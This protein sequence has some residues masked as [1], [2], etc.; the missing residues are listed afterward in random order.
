MRT[1]H[2]EMRISKFLLFSM[3]IC[4]FLPPSSPDPNDESCLTH[5]FQSFVDPNKN[6]RNWTIPNFSNPCSDFNSMLVGAT[7]N[8]G[9]VYKLSLQNLGLRGPISPFISNCTNLQSLDLSNNSLAGP[10]P[11]ELQYL[12]NLAVLNLSS[13]HLSAAIPPSLAMCNYLNVIDLHDNDLTGTI[14]PQLGSLVRLSVFDVS[15]NKLSGPI[16]A[17]LGNRMGNLPRLNAS[18]FSGN[19]DLYGYPLGP[20]NSKGLSVVAIVGIGLGSGLLSLVLSFT[21]VCI[22][23]RS[24]E[25]KR[26]DEHEGKIPHSMPDY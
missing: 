17:S 13:N 20:M 7:C 23:L 26:V 21:V 19:K 8:N 2:R 25:Q 10:I 1:A 11:V 5:L 12:V 24:T 18:S 15:N 9:R 3:L 6:L 22:W 4:T 16:P 14:P